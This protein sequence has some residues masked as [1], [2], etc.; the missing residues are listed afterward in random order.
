MGKIIAVIPAYNEEARVSQVINKAGRFVDEIIVVDDCSTDNT[1]A[2][3][4]DKGATLISLNHNRGVGFATRTGCNCAVDKGAEIIVTLDA[5]GQHNSADIPKLLRPLLAQEADITFG[6]RSRDKRMPFDKRVG[7]VL[8]SWLAKVLFRS[9]LKD[10]LTGFHAFKSSC[11]HALRWNSAGYGVV[12]EI[13][14]RTIKN[15]L[16][17]KQVGV[18]TI[19]NG[20]KRGMSKK[21]G[22]KSILLMFKWKIKRS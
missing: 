4:Q 1:A 20:K 2:V 6:I 11:Y 16:R 12:S 18:E 8:F 14:Y 21:D 3:S 9:D 19:Y 15:N 17:Y 10:V 7:N 5:D 22:I 13:A